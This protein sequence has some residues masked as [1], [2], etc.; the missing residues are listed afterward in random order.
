MKAFG[1]KIALPIVFLTALAPNAARA[2][3]DGTV[4]SLGEGY[5]LYQ[6]VE[7]CGLTPSAAAMDILKAAIATFEVKADEETKKSLWAEAAE[8][9][10]SIQLLGICPMIDA[11]IGLIE[12]MESANRPVEVPAKP[13]F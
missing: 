1:L 4:E 10:P 7:A 2:A 11:E 5:M 9:M 3:F 13:S 12:T 8:D 6:A